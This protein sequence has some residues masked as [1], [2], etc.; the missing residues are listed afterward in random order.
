[1]KLLSAATATVPI[2]TRIFKAFFFRPRC[3]LHVRFFHFNKRHFLPRSNVPCS[4]ILFY[5]YNTIFISIMDAAQN[6]ISLEETTY[7]STI[8]QKQKQLLFQ[9]ILCTV[10]SIIFYI[11]IAIFVY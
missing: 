8:I 1:M 11:N 9:I 7:V 10:T 3:D 5:C 4:C 2:L 6:N